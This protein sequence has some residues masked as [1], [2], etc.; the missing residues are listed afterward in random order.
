MPVQLA[1]E[2]F[3]A[4]GNVAK[5]QIIINGLSP[6]YVLSQNIGH[7][8]TWKKE[9]LQ[10]YS[11]RKTGRYYTVLQYLMSQIAWIRNPNSKR[12]NKITYR[13]LYEYNGDKSTRAK[14]L[15]RDMAYRLLTEV[16]KPAGYV[17]SFKE[18]NKGEPGIVIRC[19]K[20]AAAALPNS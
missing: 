13:E 3:I 16:F 14:Q 7:F 11:G 17:S 1:S 19:S 2:K 10:L 4:N 6:F 15:T 20:N 18:D 5:A 12:N 8:T 9:I